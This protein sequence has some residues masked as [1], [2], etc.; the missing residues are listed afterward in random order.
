MICSP[1]QDLLQEDGIALLSRQVYWGFGC[2]VPLLHELEKIVSAKEIKNLA[3]FQVFYVL[4]GK[5]VEGSVFLWFVFG[6]EEVPQ[7]QGRVFHKVN[8]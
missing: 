4:L 7:L 8:K 1:I 5:D 6:P 2:H 3:G